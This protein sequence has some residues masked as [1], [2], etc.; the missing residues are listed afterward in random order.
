ML[1]ASFSLTLLLSAD[2]V[3]LPSSWLFAAAASSL[4]ILALNA[5]HTQQGKA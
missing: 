5:A 1:L 3:L 4:N 2:A